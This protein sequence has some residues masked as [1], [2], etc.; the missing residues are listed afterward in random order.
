MTKEQADEILCYVA[1][2]IIAPFA[3]DK[4][5]N[6]DVWKQVVEDNFS[7]LCK[8]VYGFVDK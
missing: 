3:Y 5:A 4:K 2:E 1:Q 8:I 7:T 6:L